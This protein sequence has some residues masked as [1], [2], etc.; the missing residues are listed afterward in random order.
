MLSLKTSALGALSLIAL[1]SLPCAAADGDL[2]PDFGTGGIAY[3][4]PDLVAAQEYTPA[5]AI[6]LPDGKILVGGTLDKPT[7]VPFEQ[8]Y[9]GMLAR[10]NADGSVDDTFG[11][12]SVAGI[13]EV[14]NL[15]DGA[16]MEGIESM[17]RLDD[18]SI[19]A[20]GTSMV[21]TPLQGFIIKMDA[22]GNL[23]PNF[24]TG[25]AVFSLSTFLHAV[26]VDGAGR[27][28]AAGE[29]VASGVYTSTVIRLGADGTPDDAFGTSGTATIDWDGAGNSGYLT[30]L[31]VNADDSVTVGGMYSVYGD[32]FGNDYA[33]ARLD[34]TGTLDATFGDN[35]SRVFHDPSD[36][37]FINAIHSI[38]PTPDGGIAWAG[39]FTNPDGYAQIIIG[40][41]DANGLTDA[42]FG[43][44]A[45][46]GYFRPVIV[47][48]QNN[49]V[50][51]LAVQADGKPVV[52]ATYWVSDRE[53]FFAFRATADGQA[54]T[55]FADNGAFNVDLAPSGTYS[56]AS[57]VT[58][59]PD[60]RI[61]AAGR[62][63]RSDVFQVDL[64]I[65]RLLSA[66]GEPTDRIFASGFE[67]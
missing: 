20:V 19:V 31:I 5:A 3:I 4:T 49:N 13:V 63:E 39:Y 54:D 22:E 60:G 59:Q 66:G 62:A 2:D 47:P 56:E 29:H 10:F 30:T 48:V 7:S 21:N 50:T 23:D 1:A 55:T 8:E 41:L 65:V 26:G 40:H 67:P 42:A 28:L 35:G 34:D 9:R 6:V 52:T 11:N 37:S 38:A 27:I 32:G 57:A 12:T 44:E 36:P 18:G 53:E 43:D 17:V 33:V 45:T 61:V 14:P 51:G 46:P 58:V 15:V 16:R 64:G 24:G 25:G